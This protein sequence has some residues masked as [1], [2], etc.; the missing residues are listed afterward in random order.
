MATRQHLMVAE[1]LW[2]RTILVFL[3]HMAPEHI[4]SI[5]LSSPYILEP[6]TMTG[7]LS[8]VCLH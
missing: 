5:L 6:F 4:Y 8:A 2:L 7:P 3:Y 1:R